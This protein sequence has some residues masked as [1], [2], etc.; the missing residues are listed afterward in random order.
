MDNYLLEFED[1]GVAGKKANKLKY[2]ADKVNESECDADD[3][4]M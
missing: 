2:N 1:E 4:L 3:C